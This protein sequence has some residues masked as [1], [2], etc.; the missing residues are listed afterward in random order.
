[1]ALSESDIIAFLNP[2]T[3]TDILES[4]HN[5]KFYDQHTSTIALRLSQM[6]PARGCRFGSDEKLCDVVIK[7]SG[8]SAVHFRI[9]V[10]FTTGQLVLTDMSSSNTVVESPNSEV[11]HLRKNSHPVFSGDIIQAA[12]V[13]FK[14]NIP[15]HA[16]FGSPYNEE[17]EAYR[18]RASASLPALDALDIK[19]DPS[20]TLHA[21][22]S[23]ILLPG[24]QFSVTQ[25]AVD[26]MGNYYAVKRW[27]KEKG[28]QVRGLIHVILLRLYLNRYANSTQPHLTRIFLDKLVSLNE[29]F[30]VAEW[31][32]SHPTL[33]EQTNLLADEMKTVI[34]QVL[35]GMAYMHERGMVHRDIQPSNIFIVSRTL[36]RCK[37][38][39]IALSGRTTYM[40]PEVVSRKSYPLGPSVD[41]WSIG[42]SILRF[43]L[44]SPWFARMSEWSG[45]QCIGAQASRPGPVWQALTSLGNTM[46]EFDCNNRPSATDCLEKLSHLGSMHSTSEPK[47]NLIN[48]EFLSRQT[49]I[50]NVSSDLLP[51]IPNIRVEPYSITVA[52][53]T[54]RKA[55]HIS[56]TE[57]N[58]L[59]RK[60][61]GK[62]HPD[63]KYSQRISLTD[64]AALLGDSRETSNWTTAVELDHLDRHLNGA[65]RAEMSTRVGFLPDRMLLYQTGCHLSGWLE[66][67]S[68]NIAVCRV[69]TMEYR[70]L[71]RGR[72]LWLNN[73]EDR[74]IVQVELGDKEKK[75]KLT[76]NFTA[77]S[78]GDWGHGKGSEM[79]VE[80]QRGGPIFRCQIGSCHRGVAKCRNASRSNSCVLSLSRSLSLN[81]REDLFWNHLAHTR[82]KRARRNFEAC[83]LHADKHFGTSDIEVRSSPG[84]AKLLRQTEAQGAL[85]FAI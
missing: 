10:R 37:V 45:G 55:L 61:V 78:G 79:T 70:I 35:D 24:N 8:I 68:L 80:G 43:S 14:I 53:L 27:S 57:W 65:H 67:Y 39:C 64:L 72:P 32:T 52:T 82:Q 2:Q 18:Q 20:L 42:V 84:L 26:C 12:L 81:S 71:V 11:K 73:G 74:T 83:F 19:R 25:K 4:P 36:M 44:F 38:G 3:E 41:I 59:F 34:E 9:D 85:V 63:A 1:M 69:Y 33:A 28:R 49:S 31:T 46:L 30:I 51:L 6:D 5:T 58:S 56:S 62:V 17:L 15:S 23:L 77:V 54:A 13:R 16:R 22:A 48:L 60:T 47:Q 50:P 21:P 7:K 66:H 29:A 40:A 76:G 75:K